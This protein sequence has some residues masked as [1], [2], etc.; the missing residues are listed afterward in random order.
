MVNHTERA[1]RS[2]R[3]AKPLKLLEKM[4]F[5]DFQLTYTDAFFD[6]LWTK[7]LFL[8]DPE[9]GL[10]ETTIRSMEDE[11]HGD[12]DGDN[13]RDR[14]DYSDRDRGTDGM[15]D[16]GGRGEPKKWKEMEERGDTNKSDRETRKSM[17][18]GA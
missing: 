12:G 11:R 4:E 1:A 10:T 14:D 6:E 18:C 9:K 2:I 7:R 15:R 5:E 13:Y 16:G 8:S 17:G 3:G